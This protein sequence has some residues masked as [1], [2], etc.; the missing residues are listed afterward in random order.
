MDSDNEVVDNEVLPTELKGC[1]LSNLPNFNYSNIRSTQRYMGWNN[2]IFGYNELHSVTK[3]YVNIA[4]SIDIFVKNNPPT[5]IIT[6]KT[7]LMQYKS[8][9]GV[10]VF[11]N[12]GKAALQKELHQFH[13]H[14]VV[15][16]EKPQDLSYEQRRRILAYMI[17]L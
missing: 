6:N 16:P 8:K 10:N 15:K 12:N 2:L 7:I 5:N 4:N 9:Q 17:F 11:G 1:I 13:N 14:R 3:S